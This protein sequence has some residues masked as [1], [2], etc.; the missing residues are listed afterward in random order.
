MK[1]VVIM[2]AGPAGLSAGYELTKEGIATLLVEKEKQVGGISKTIRCEMSTRTDTV[3]EKVTNYFD[4]GGHR[5]FTKFAEVNDLW[6]EV[7][8]DRFRKTPRLSR[9][10][11]NDRFFNYPLTAM[12]ALMGVGL[13][14]TV[15]IL[16]SYFAAKIHPSK[17]ENTFEEW[18]S[19]RFGKKLFLIFFKTYT[20]KVWGIPCSEIQAEWAAQRIKGLSLYSA[21]MNALLKPKKSKI[22]TLIDRFDYPEFGPG[23]MYNEMS[24]RILDQQGSVRLKERV[25]KV[26]HAGNR[27]TAVETEDADGETTLHEGTDFLSS[28]PITELVQILSPEAPEKVIHAA[29]SLKYRSLVTVDIMVDQEELFPDNWIYIHS[30]EVKL[31]RI[32]N[33]KNWSPSMVG[34]SA[35]STLGLEYFCNENNGFWTMPDDK[36]F[37]QASEEVSKIKICERDRIED[38]L[39][40]RVPKAYPV[41]DMDYPQHIRLIREYLDLFENLQ[42]IGRYGLFKYNNMDHSILTGLYAAKNIQAG[43]KIHDIWNINTDEEYH[44]EKQEK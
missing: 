36:I 38:F 12:N 6:Q 3:S 31:G 25:V 4:L 42:P 35:R 28:I 39:V 18:V 30:P 24:S 26:H 19:N 17:T 33:F 41:Y 27:V 7:L 2:G 13:A 5:F 16:L 34:S 20:E 8:G 43:K 23:M 21:V 32:Q 22:T 14:D 15:K 10:Y 44:E 1:K 37:A 29:K 11:Y 40:V 9:I